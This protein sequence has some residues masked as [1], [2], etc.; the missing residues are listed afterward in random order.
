M[1]VEDFAGVNPDTGEPRN[2][3]EMQRSLYVYNLA[4]QANSPDML[5]SVILVRC[6]PAYIGVDGGGMLWRRVM[7]WWWW[8]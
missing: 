8:R 1:S 3:T 6:F 2:I 5:G 4:A 7:G